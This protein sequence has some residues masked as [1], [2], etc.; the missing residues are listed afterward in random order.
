MKFK[1]ALLTQVSGS[2]GGMTFAHN[3]GGLYIRTRAIPTDPNSAFQA[4]L[5]AVFGALVQRWEATL[6]PAQRNVWDAYAAAV[7]LTGPLG[8]PITV[9]GLNHYLRSNT[10]RSRFGLPVLDD[11]PNILNLG[12]LSLVTVTNATG[13][14]QSVDVTFTAGDAWNVAG[15]ALFIFIARTQNTTINFFRGPYL[16]A[17]ALLGSGPAVPP[18]TVSSPFFFGA[19]RRMFLRAVATLPDGRYTQTQFIGPELTVA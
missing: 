2:I 12:T 18:T 17:A 19:G 10:S 16:F 8:D 3:R 5:R 13:A 4:A 11:A 6:T 7:P 14:G 1:S 9:S 15:G